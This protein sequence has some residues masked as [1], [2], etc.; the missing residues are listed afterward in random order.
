MNY[1]HDITSG[2]NTWQGSPGRFYAVAGYDLCCGLGTMN[3]TNLINALAAPAASPFFLARAA[4]Y[5]LTTNEPCLDGAINPGETATVGL[6]L[7]NI[8]AVAF[9]QPCRDAAAL[10]SLQG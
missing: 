8:G 4:G 3:G 10:F 1:F 9:D 7:Q 5:T 6:I 2:N